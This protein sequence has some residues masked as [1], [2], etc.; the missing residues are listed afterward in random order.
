MAAHWTDNKDFGWV[1]G[2]HF[3]LWLH[4]RFGIWPFRVVLF[5]VVLVSILLNPVARRGAVDYW[6]R[7]NPAISRWRLALGVFKQ[8]WAFANSMLYR[9]LILSRQYDLSATDIHGR[10]EFRSVIDSGQGALLIGSHHGNVEA[11][12]AMAGKANRKVCALVHTEH[13]E[14][15]NKA[16]SAYTKD[17]I[18]LI[19]VT[20]V[21]VETAFVLS[22][23][24]AQGYLVVITADRVP[25]NGGRTISV[26]FLGEPAEFPQGPFMLAALLKCPVFFMFCYRQGDHFRINFEYAYSRLVLERGNREQ[27]LLEACSQYSLSLEKHVR[28]APEQWFNFY[29][30]WGSSKD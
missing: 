12:K 15:F 3:M 17:S 28:S 24:I 9:L 4:R 29:P 20:S 30:F 19:Q 25:V 14:T 16:V 27:G 7:I 11:C 2:I 8:F 23:K 6:R 5:P 18:E 10:K 22:E 13:A 21:G 26:P 1:R